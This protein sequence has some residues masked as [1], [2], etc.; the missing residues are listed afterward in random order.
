VDLPD[1][2]PDYITVTE[3]DGIV[4]AKFNAAHLSDDDN[5]EQLGRELF[6]LV[7]R[8]H[9]TKMAL[10]LSN[11][12]GLSSSILGK[13]ITL[14]RKL[15]RANGTLV[16]CDIN[17]RVANVMKTTRLFDYF[18]TADDLDGAIRLLG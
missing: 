9:F 8:F 4:C 2:D 14:H 13:M 1:F 7:E 10:S 18:N 12:E 5:V 17:E 16:I 15:H 11:V 3:T 6:A